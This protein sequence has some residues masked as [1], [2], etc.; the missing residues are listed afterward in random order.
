M[1]GS[2]PIADCLAGHL[3]PRAALA[4]LLLAGENP[5]AIERR[6]TEYE[7][8]S[9]AGRELAHI[10]RLNAGP[11]A[12]SAA[13]L[14]AASLNHSV[15]QPQPLIAAAF[16]RASAIAPDAAAAL[17]TLGE[18]AALTAASTEI[19]DWLT[20]QSLI[21]PGSRVLDLGC[22]SGRLSAALAGCCHLVVGTDISRG[23]LR[24][25]RARGVP[26][27][28]FLQTSGQDLACL[29][30]ETFDLILAV[31]TFPY[32]MLAQDSAA[33]RHFSEAARLLRPRG[34]LAILNFSYRNDAAADR[35]DA[36]R[37]CLAS[38]L[39]LTQPPARFRHWDATAYVARKPPTPSRARDPS[40]PAARPP[41]WLKQNTEPNM[42][43]KSKSEEASD[44]L[45]EAE[46][47]RKAGDRD[48][49]EFLT[50]AAKQLD[51]ET[52]AKTKSRPTASPEHKA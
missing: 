5:A 19:I 16:D 48:E 52:P 9:D 15:R 25:A 18:E 33:A 12:Q 43:E 36:A 2:D 51:P 28:A 13:M 49:A 1:S 34:A 31:D 21:G 24:A 39:S 22:G 7:A 10:A 6:A 32:L 37:W 44:L 41:A 29:R 26:G 30:S 50:N 35:A 45:R 3:P 14:Q 20:G 27:S 42:T 11:I 38:G 23:M 8:V 47:A 46:E 40:Q 17:Y 4:R